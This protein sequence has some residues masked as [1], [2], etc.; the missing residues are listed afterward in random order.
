[1]ATAEKR[2]IKAFSEFCQCHLGH[3]AA[4]REVEAKKN[5]NTVEN[6]SS[7]RHQGAAKP[8]LARLKP[9]PTARPDERIGKFK[10]SRFGL[11]VT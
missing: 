7:K 5:G 3:S 9:P 4:A 1:M 8:S 11:Y 2:F 10:H 6:A